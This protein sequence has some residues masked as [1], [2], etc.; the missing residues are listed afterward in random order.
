MSNYINQKIVPSVI[1][2]SNTKIIK[3]LKDGMMFVLPFLIVGSLFMLLANIP[4]PAVANAITASGWAAIFNQIYQSSF[5]LMAIFATV[6]IAYT[7]IKNEQIDSPFS[8]SLAALSAFIMVLP[9]DIKPKAGQIIPNVISKTWTAGQGMICAIII[10]LLAGY[11]YSFCVKKNWRIKL[12]TGVPPAVASSFMALIPTG[13]VLIVA[14][15]ICACFTFLAKTSFAELIYSAIQVPLQGVT[16]SLGGV[17][18]MTIVMSLLWWC[19]VHGGAICGAILTPILQSN[20]SANQAILA[21]G[22]KLTIANGGHIFTQQFWDNYLCMTGAGIVMGLVIYM[23]FFAKSSTLKELGKLSLF[24]NI[25]N[26]NEPVIFGV[27]IV[28]N[29]YLLVPFVL[30]PTLVGIFSYWLMAIGVLPLFSGVMVP[31]TTPPIISGFLIGG[32]RTALWQFVIIALSAIV[33]WPFIK[34]YDQVLLQ[35]Q[36]SKE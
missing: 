21:T 30:F 31:W 33:Y 9:P 23:T 2:F 4:I 32:W 36:Q 24:P 26:I 22:K 11:I 12:P 1:K 16:D 14:G 27:P 18:I 25:F 5:S 3:A 28:M 20:M 8:G 7:Y 15:A 34:K 19:G 6:G 35:Q 29:L 17:V 13:A 10:G